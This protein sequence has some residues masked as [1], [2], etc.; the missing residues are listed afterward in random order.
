MLEKRIHSELYNALTNNR[1]I[2]QNQPIT[3]QVLR[4]R[5][6]VDNLQFPTIF[7]DYGDAILDGRNTPLNEIFSISLIPASDGLEDIK[8]T[9]GV[10][11]QQSINLNL[12]DNDIRRVAE[13][14]DQLFLFCKQLSL[15]GITVFQ[16]N[17]PRVLDFTE[18]DYIYRRLVEVVCKFIVS[19]EEIVKTIEE[20][21]ISVKAQ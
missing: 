21:E 12:Y 16:V 18:G 13:L 9:K 11:V 17:P 4:A 19:W 8:Y 14:Q 20:T 5:Q 2:Y 6:V 1:W 15:T 10:V 7:I 3:V